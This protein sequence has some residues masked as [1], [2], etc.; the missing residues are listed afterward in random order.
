L[1]SKRDR[2]PSKHR[3]SIADPRIKR[4]DLHAHQKNKPESG[5]SSMS[6]MGQRTCQV[7]SFAL[8]VLRDHGLHDADF[9][10]ICFK[11][12]D[13][14]V[15]V[16]SADW[17]AAIMLN[18]YGQRSRLPLHWMCC[19]GRKTDDNT[20]VEDDIPCLIRE[21]A[22]INYKP[23]GLRIASPWVPPWR[24]VRA[25]DVALLCIVPGKVV[26]CWTRLPRT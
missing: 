2:E 17:S 10:E 11:P 6:S 8:C 24:A 9:G 1:S 7:P 16:G 5:A 21:Q 13:S 22:S 26:P 12:M 3:T 20:S 19:S 4:G 18:N 14:S 25:D 23:E 15:L